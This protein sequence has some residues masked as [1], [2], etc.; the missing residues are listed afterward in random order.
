MADEKNISVETLLK[1][2]EHFNVATLLGKAIQAAAYQ[3]EH[4][5]GNGSRD[6]IDFASTISSPVATP[7]GP[8]FPSD[9]YEANI[10]NQKN[11][12]SALL[13]PEIEAFIKPCALYD[14][15]LLSLDQLGIDP[16]SWWD[17]KDNNAPDFVLRLSLAWIIARRVFAIRHSEEAIRLI[18]A[19]EYSIEKAKPIPF[20]PFDD[21]DRKFVI[22][23][24]N[25]IH[26][27]DNIS[28]AV[29]DQQQK[30]IMAEK[31]E[32][33]KHSSV[34]SSPTSLAFW[35]QSEAAATG[36]SK[37]TGKKKP[38]KIPGVYTK[39]LPVDIELTI[40]DAEGQPIEITGFD[41]ALQATIGQ[42]IREN[43]NRPV[44]A[45]PA[46]IFRKCA[47]LDA[48][49]SVSPASIEET[50]A[51]INKMRQADTTIAYA[52]QLSAFLK[53]DSKQENRQ[54]DFDY[55]V[56]KVEGKLIN[57]DRSRTA[58]V[59]S[60]GKVI[61]DVFIFYRAPIIEHYS[62]GFRQL[63]EVDKKYLGGALNKATPENI[64]FA[65]YLL[66]QI[67]HM[68]E[69]KAQGKPYNGLLTFETIAA[70]CVYD[71]SSRGKMR[72]FQA[73]VMDYCENLVSLGM[74]KKAEQ[75]YKGKA[76]TG[77]KITL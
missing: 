30:A 43:N 55:S 15:F 76:Y 72:N 32:Q 18:S 28:S 58:F 19:L 65:R 21:T 7:D 53:K 22:E 62:Y 75:Y 3:I 23:A 64:S 26:G 38:I 45:T 48:N 6:R 9:E 50:V 59:S 35:N 4:P 29:T 13:I 42:M 36:I 40:A 69:E 34:I 77:V 47:G 67:N 24:S 61:D 1:L 49:A 14:M 52:Q 56:S 2:D 25:S 60:N 70:R 8:V 73:K 68:K 41:M 44:T 12:I 31:L 39:P 66:V 11:Q 17:I 74:I 10:F 46:Q 33:L 20:A 57:A 63:M 16:G 37:K 54:P 5:A 71:I 27:L 51:A